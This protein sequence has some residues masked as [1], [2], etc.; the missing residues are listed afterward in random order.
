MAK[1]TFKSIGDEI[2]FND[3]VNEMA[4]RCGSATVAEKLLVGGLKDGRV[5]WSHMLPDG[6]RVVGDAA[7]WNGF[8]LTVDRAENGA[9][10]GAPTGPIAPG[11][12]GV[13]ARV[14]GIKVSRKAALALV[15]AAP[16]GN[17]SAKELI[18]AEA[19][20]MKRDGEIPEGILKTHFAKALADKAGVTK[21]YVSNNLEAWSLWPVSSIPDSK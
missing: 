12:P 10:L 11:S 7:F 18:T 8:L 21:K 9:C 15:S 19:K 6:T 5:P 1:A 13:P 14:V 4:D 16:V 2:W 17:P 20:R 3:A